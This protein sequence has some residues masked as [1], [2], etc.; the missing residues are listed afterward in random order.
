MNLKYLLT[1]HWIFCVICFNKSTSKSQLIPWNIRNLLRSQNEW[2]SPIV[3]GG[4]MVSGYW[5]ELLPGSDQAA[6]HMMWMTKGWTCSRRFWR[7]SRWGWGWS[8]RMR[9]ITTR[10]RP[11]LVKGSFTRMIIMITTGVFKI[12]AGSGQIIGDGHSFEECSFRHIHSFQPDKLH[13]A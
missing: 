5:G 3:E 13:W 11:F 10:V 4:Q 12:E 9:I 6:R 8:Q 1:C 2:F 7:W